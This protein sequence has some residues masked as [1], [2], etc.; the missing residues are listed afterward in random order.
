MLELLLGIT[1]RKINAWLDEIFPHI[2]EFGPELFWLCHSLAGQ[3]TAA[4]II[5]LPHALHP[6]PKAALVDTPHITA[7]P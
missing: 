3:G 2:L 1:G 5:P 7:A 6:P 4:L